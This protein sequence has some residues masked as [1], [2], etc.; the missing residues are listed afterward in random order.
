MDYSIIEARGA[1]RRELK[2]GLRKE[3]KSDLK[4]VH[5]RLEGRWIMDSNEER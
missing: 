5:V 3:H 4:Y 2:G 1:I